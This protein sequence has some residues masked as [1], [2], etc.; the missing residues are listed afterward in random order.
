MAKAE[1]MLSLIKAHFNNEDEHF[2]TIAL[3]MAAHEAKLGH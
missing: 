2:L 3:Q 1:Y